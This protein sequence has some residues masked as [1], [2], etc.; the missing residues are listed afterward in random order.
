MVRRIL[1]IVY[2]DPCTSV[3]FSY[4]VATSKIPVPLLEIGALSDA[5]LP[6]ASY[7]FELDEDS[8]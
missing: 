8:L 4:M 5:D 6:I 7:G 2:D 1:E 3:K